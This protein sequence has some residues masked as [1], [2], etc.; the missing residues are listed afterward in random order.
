MKGVGQHA[1]F[2][3]F[4]TINAA[5]KIFVEIKENRIRVT[6]KVSH[7][8]L[9][10]ASIGSVESGMKLIGDCFPF[11]E[12][13]DHKDSYAMAYIN[14]NANAMDK[15]RSLIDF[16]NNHADSPLEDDDW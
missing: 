2:Y 13:G 4:T 7:Y 8:N 14:C 12:K 10:S 16:L 9:G 11:N 3:S 15:I 5:V 1:G 6:S